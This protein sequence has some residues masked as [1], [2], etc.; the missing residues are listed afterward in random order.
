MNSISILRVIQKSIEKKARRRHQKTYRMN[1]MTNNYVC[2]F[3]DTQQTLTN[4][5]EFFF[6]CLI[7]VPIYLSV[8]EHDDDYYYYHI[9]MEMTAHIS[10]SYTT[11]YYYCF[12]YF[13]IRQYEVICA[14]FGANSFNV[15]VK[16]TECVRIQQFVRHRS[17]QS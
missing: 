3:K 15:W 8:C 5:M 2:T 17:G 13:V 11:C 9:L 14:H 1:K 12:Y 6:L 4:N 16:Y 10:S 7:F